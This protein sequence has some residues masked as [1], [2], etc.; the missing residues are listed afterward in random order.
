MAVV[1]VAEPNRTERFG[2]TPQVFNHILASRKTIGEKE[3]VARLVGT[4]NPVVATQI[5]FM[6]TL[7]LG[8]DGPNFDDHIFQ[9]GW[10]NH[11]PV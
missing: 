2:A 11:Q 9:I 6:L 3:K 4:M 5:F 10:F 7:N 1:S 8:E